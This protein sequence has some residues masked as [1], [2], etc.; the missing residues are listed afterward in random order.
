MTR[1]ILTTDSSAAGSLKAAGRAEIT[2][3][4]E[5]RLVW[6]PLRPEGELAMLLARPE[7][8]DDWLWSVYRKY[9]GKIDRDEIGLIDFCERSE[10]IELWIDPE[11]NAQLTLIWLLGYLRPHEK[12]ASRL[13]LVQAETLI[14]NNTP[15]QLAIRKPNAIDVTN[16]HFEIAD[17]AWRAYGAPT[18]EAWF[19]LLN[20]D[21]SILPRLRAGVVELLEE[22]P[23]CM[24]G[25][26]A[27][28]M[29]L[30][31][32]IA[33]GVRTPYDVFPGHRKRNKRRVFG[34]WEVGSLL[35]GLARCPAPAVTGLDEGPFD[36]ALVC[37]RERRQRYQRSVLSLTTLGEAILARTEDF[38]RHNPIHRWWGGTRLTNDNLWRW[39][40]EHRRVVV[41]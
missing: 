23:H 12:V 1:L 25:L 20:K 11:P 7:A 4:L 41:P 26:G 16:D 38:S 9:F 8:A 33:D 24:T 32:L 10:T 6:G 15:R 18:P 30:L 17:R 2:L 3:P 34:Y 36:E 5:P 40:P 28:E 14:G 19:D 21:L 31:E 37:D 39:D 22:L 27:T 13:T 29:R 35:D